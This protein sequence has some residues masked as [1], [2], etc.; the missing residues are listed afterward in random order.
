[1]LTLRQYTQEKIKAIGAEYGKMDDAQCG[2]ITM[3]AQ[4]EWEALFWKIADDAH[5][6]DKIVFS[7][8]F[9]KKLIR[10]YDGKYLAEMKKRRP[11]A[12]A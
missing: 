2:D 1:M 3:Q 7:K 12:F 4:Q 8:Q 10:E 5:H 11:R 9:Q 6:A